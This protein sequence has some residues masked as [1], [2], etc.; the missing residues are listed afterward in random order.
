MKHEFWFLLSVLCTY[1]C[2]IICIDKKEISI[3]P[4]KELCIQGR[5]ECIGSDKAAQRVVRA[6]VLECHGHIYR[7][8]GRWKQGAGACALPQIWAELEA[9]PVPPKDLISKR[10]LKPYSNQAGI[11]FITAT[12]YHVT[13]PSWNR[14]H[15]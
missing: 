3:A 13:K 15:L 1:I 8:Q 7:Y 12:V 14:V 5:E 2:N 9:N 11:P 10:L 6:W 4:K